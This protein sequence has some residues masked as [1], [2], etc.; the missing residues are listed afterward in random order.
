VIT[1]FQ[2]EMLLGLDTFR[3]GLDITRRVLDEHRDALLATG[4]D[5]REREQFAER[6]EAEWGRVNTTDLAVETIEN[7]ILRPAVESLSERFTDQPSVEARLRFSLGDQYFSLGKYEQGIALMRDASDVLEREFPPDHPVPLRARA[8]LAFYLSSTSGVNESVQMIEGVLKRLRSAVDLDPLLALSIREQAAQIFWAAGKLELALGAA[9]ASWEGFKAILGEDDPKTLRSL[10]TLAGVTRESGDLA[11]ARV[12]EDDVLER[13]RRVL[14][15]DSPDTIRS[16]SSSANQAWQER[17]IEQALELFNEA[18][19]ARARVHGAAHPITLQSASNY[20]QAL[21][22]AGD[23]E[24]GNA[25]MR[26]SLESMSEA[27]GEDAT[28]VLTVASNLSVQLTEAG[29]YE[30]AERLALDTLARRRR[31]LGD[32]HPDTLVSFNVASYVYR[33]QRLHEKAEPYL[34]MALRVATETLG[35]DHPDR[36]I[37]LFNV[38]SISVS[39]DRTDEAIALLSETAVRGSAVLGLRHPT[40]SRAIGRVSELLHNEGRHAQLIELLAPMIPL[41]RQETEAGES[42]V[43]GP[44]LHSVGRA[45]SQLGQWDNAE[46]NL[47]EAYTI[48]IDSEDQGRALREACINALVD[49]FIRRDVDSPDQG[50]AERA[51]EWEARLHVERETGPP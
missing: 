16:I 40:T 27:M 4:L 23:V 34:R 32:S 7:L 45:Q 33:T 5:D 26:D 50:F 12:L 9:T 42:S 38:G 44:M 49:H 37:Y 35:P 13:R 29:E 41:A 8:A 18:Y 17:R 46:A 10:Q 30:E 1:E 19:E 36:L 21:A 22:Q 24:R 47:K 51:G 20:A 39:L 14:G 3:A 31:L 28:S 6:F 15:P 25:I 11:G 43:L 48:A 2:S